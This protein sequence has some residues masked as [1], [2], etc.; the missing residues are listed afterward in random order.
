VAELQRA[1]ALAGLNYSGKFVNSLINMVDMDCSG[2]LSPQEFL[3]VHQHLRA[4]YTMF[5]QSDADRSG[6]LTLNEIAPALQRL[7]FNLDMSPSGSFYTL[8]KSFDFDKSGRFSQDIF[9]AIYVQ[10]QNARKVHQKLAQGN[11]ALSFDVY[12]WSIAQL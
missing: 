4:A 10:L 5:V 11:P 9:I 2:Q 6:V 8:L 7:G 12:I 1:L 3:T